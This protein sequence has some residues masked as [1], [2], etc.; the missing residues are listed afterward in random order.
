[1]SQTIWSKTSSPQK[2]RAC[3]HFGVPSRSWPWTWNGL[4]GQAN[5]DKFQQK[6]EEFFV[7]K[8]TEVGFHLECGLTFGLGLACALR[9]IVKNK[10]EG[11][12]SH[13]NI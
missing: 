4:A 11:L 3:R 1:M 13:K 12:Y 6:V 10:N 9:Q 7:K 5:R 2:S 8:C